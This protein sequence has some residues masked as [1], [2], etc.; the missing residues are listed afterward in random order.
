[1]HTGCIAP[2]HKALA[3]RCGGRHRCTTQLQQPIKLYR[4]TAAAG[5]VW[6]V[7]LVVLK[8]RSVCTRGRQAICFPNICLWVPTVLNISTT[9]CTIQPCPATAAGLNISPVPSVA[10]NAGASYTR[11][12]S[13]VCLGPKSCLEHDEGQWSLRDGT[14]VLFTIAEY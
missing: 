6:T 13:L 4:T 7:H 8:F 11:A 5:W 9:R 12:K 1:M 2:V 3:F 10:P 14:N